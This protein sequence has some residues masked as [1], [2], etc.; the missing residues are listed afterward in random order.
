MQIASNEGERSILQQDITLIF[1]ASG[2]LRNVV[3]TVNGMPGILEGLL[4]RH[5]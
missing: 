1:A 2:D 5:Q 3:K 4:R